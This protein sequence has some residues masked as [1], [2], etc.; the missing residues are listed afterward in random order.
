MKFPKLFAFLAAASLVMFSSCEDDDDNDVPD[1]ITGNCK[2]VKVTDENGVSTIT[3]TNDKITSLKT[4]EMGNITV[5]YHTTGAANG[6]VSELNFTAGEIG[7]GFVEYMYNN[8]G[9]LGASLY[10]SEFFSE[11][12]EG[13]A[14]FSE[15]EYSAGKISKVTRY[16]LIPGEPGED[17]TMA[18]LSYSTFE[19]NAKGNMI[20]MKEYEDNP[21][22]PDY[23]TEFTYDDKFN[24]SAE[25]E[26]LL[27]GIPGLTPGSP[28]NQLTVLRKQGSTVVKDESYTNTY[29]YSSGGFPTKITTTPQQGAVTVANIE[30]SCK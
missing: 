11:I 10:T 9:R 3:Y 25:L 20:L 4:G 7:A 21:T 27:L 19:Y 13:A 17:P 23:T 15:F 24:P 14:L 2:P 6:K 29:V 28:N 16:L 22:T 8:Q 1:P 18:P 12:F 26:N 5:T 30:Y